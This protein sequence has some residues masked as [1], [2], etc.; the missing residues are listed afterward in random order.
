MNKIK[1]FLI[2]IRKEMTKIR[3]PK[4]KELLKSSVATI[5]VVLVLAVFFT[6][7]DFVFSSL[8]KWGA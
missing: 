3:W 6:G 8:M 1:L 2:E 7:L 5:G 4:K